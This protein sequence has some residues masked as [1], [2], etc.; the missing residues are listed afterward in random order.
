MNTLENSKEITELLEKTFSNVNTW[1][2]FAEAK[3]AA[4]IAF[5]VACISVIDI[6]KINAFSCFIMIL[7]IISGII[8]MI[9]FWPNVGS[10]W[11]PDNKL[12]NRQ[13]I[14]L[15]L[16]SHIEVYSGKEYLDKVYERYFPK[17]EKQNNKYHLDVADEI[18]YNSHITTCKYCCFK[19]AAI[20]DIF[21]LF[22]FI[23]LFIMA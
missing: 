14:N 9:S 18:V 7:L 23:I 19:G 5:V 1:L 3:N 16:F 21:A 12:K 13:D 11:K 2:H 6:E 22:L 4:N 15:V 20:V 17:M 8:S 10:I